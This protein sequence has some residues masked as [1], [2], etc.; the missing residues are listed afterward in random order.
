M[1]LSNYIPQKAFDKRIARVPLPHVEGILYLWQRD[2]SDMG[3]PGPAM[4]WPKDR[5]RPPVPPLPTPLRLYSPGPYYIL[6]PPL[7]QA[8]QSGTV[9]RGQGGSHD[10]VQCAHRAR[11]RLRRLRDVWLPPLGTRLGAGAWG[12]REGGCIVAVHGGYHF[13]PHYC[14]AMDLPSSLATTS[15]KSLA[16]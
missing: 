15:A 9:L 10:S 11:V 1:R 6:P 4:S 13:P 7:P 12:W 3:N 5:P 14:R 8:V 16:S 2:T